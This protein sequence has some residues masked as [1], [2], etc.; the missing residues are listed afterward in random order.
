MMKDISKSED[1]LGFLLYTLDVVITPTPRKILQ[2]FED[3]D[4]EHRLRPQL[5]RLE[6]ANLLHRQGRGQEAI[7]Q[8]TSE[9]R[10][11]AHGGLDP[12]ER[13]QRAWD[14]RWR[15]LLFDFPARR[16]GL[17]LRVWRWL[18]RERFGYLQNS[19]WLSPDP[20]NTDRLPLTLH[21]LNAESFVVLE[22]RP[23]P[24]DLDSGLV[25]GA[26]DFALVNRRYQS[27]LDLAA[28]GLKLAENP[29]LRPAQFR[30][31]LASEREAWLAAVESDPLLPESLLP[32]EYLGRE[33]WTQRQAAFTAVARRI[34]R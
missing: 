32:P 33:A 20:V 24:P 5:Q 27:A 8:L 19:V 31:W 34:C 21:R 22:A 1:W 7:C 6:R 10:L 30:E 16:T 23:V 2:T 11:A 15:L 25:K 17:R 3:W 29:S 12:V 28:E 13:W 4:Y 18:R 14:G 9:G 26:W